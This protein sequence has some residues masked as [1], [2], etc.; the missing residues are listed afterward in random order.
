MKCPNCH[1][2]R[3]NSKNVCE[4]CGF[5]IK[6]SDKLA[7]N[8]INFIKIFRIIAIF[9]F[10]AFFVFFIINFFSEKSVGKIFNFKL[11]FEDMVTLIV[12]I[13][14]FF[15]DGF[16]CLLAFALIRQG[17]SASKL[18][19]SQHITEGVVVDTK[20]HENH[21]ESDESVAPII[22]YEV[23]GYKYRVIGDFNNHE[24]IGN[25]VKIKYSPKKPYK[26]IVDGSNLATSSLVLGI[27]LLVVCL[28]MGLSSFFIFLF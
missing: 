20:V 26:A 28:V 16:V 10:L 14:G 1:G 17:L 2:E 8:F 9:M 5:N 3:I 4:M 24:Q 25:K 11:S 7:N 19:K 6:K 27:F 22:E 21:E 15:V 12:F 13:G 23:Y 18:N